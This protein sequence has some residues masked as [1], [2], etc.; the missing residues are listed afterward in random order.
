MDID[1]L[2]SEVKK[3]AKEIMDAEQI[4]SRVKTITNEIL[5]S[6]NISFKFL[7]RQR[8]LTNLK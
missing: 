2:D 1:R 5:I 6:D 8:Y 3:I 7:T 4:N